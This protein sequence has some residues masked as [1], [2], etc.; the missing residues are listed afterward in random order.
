MK[1]KKIWACTLILF[2]A[3]LAGATVYSR[4]AYQYG[5]P[6]VEL[7]TVKRG[8]LPG[9]E[10]FGEYDCVVQKSAVFTDPSGAKYILVVQQ[11]D[12]AWGRE[13][14]CLRQF[15]SVEAET[16]TH[17]ALICD[18][19]NYPVVT[20]SDKPLQDGSVVRLYP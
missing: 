1:G 9:A 10:D 7:D 13:Y 11:R 3:V 8:I 16:E 18:A 5:L 4:T 15:A 12:G 6:L 19:P 17:A 20:G 14:V 2:L